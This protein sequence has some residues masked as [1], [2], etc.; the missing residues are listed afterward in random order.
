V[1]ES[2][3]KFMAGG[4]FDGAKLADHWFPEIEG[5][6]FISHSH[7]DESL[8]LDL[9]GWLHENFKLRSFIDSCVW[10]GMNEM[11]KCIDDQCCKKGDELYS[12]ERRNVSTSHVHMMLAMALSRMIEKTD[13]VIFINTDNSINIKDTIATKTYSPW[14]AY[15]LA[16]VSLIKRCSASRVIKEANFSRGA[17]VQ[18]TVDLT[19]LTEIGSDILNRWET[20]WGRSDKKGSAL[21]LLYK[22]VSEASQD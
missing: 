18:H 4:V 1:V 20:S 2:I 21:E 17:M 7:A 5:D 15:E 8:A 9:A 3:E 6:I 19:S 10:G 16:I 14:I 11:L 22:L 13:C 12:Y